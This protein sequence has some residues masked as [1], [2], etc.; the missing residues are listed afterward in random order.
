[1]ILDDYTPLRTIV[2]AA[3]AD[4]ATLFQPR[5]ARVYE[6]V[7]YYSSGSGAGEYVAPN[8]PFG[9][10]LNYYLPA[11]VASAGGEIVLVISERSGERVGEVEGRG[12]VGLHRVVWNLREVPEEGEAGPEPSGRREPSPLVSPGTYLVTLVQRRNGVSRTLAGP[13]ELQVIPLG[14]TRYERVGGS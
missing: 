9:A 12:D 4:E 7:R 14:R 3:A 2:A 1:M 13:L 8:P 10:I 11:P 5:R 6:P